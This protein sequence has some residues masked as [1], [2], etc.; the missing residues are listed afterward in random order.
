MATKA[1]I[2]KQ[3]RTPKFRSRRYNRCR[4]SGR[5]RAYLRKFGVSR[6]MFRELASWGEIPGVTKASW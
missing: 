3:K 5:R 1:W 2:A 6:I 4:L